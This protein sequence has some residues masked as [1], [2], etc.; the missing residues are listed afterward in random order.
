MR[1]IRRTFADPVVDDD[2]ALE[3]GGYKMLRLR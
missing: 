2:G 3:G 1:T